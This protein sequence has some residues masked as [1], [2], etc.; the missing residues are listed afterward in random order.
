[1]SWIPRPERR[2]TRD[3]IAAGA[4]VCATA[5]FVGGT[6]VTSQQAKVDRS[7]AAAPEPHKSTATNT[8]DST[9]QH[10]AALPDALS[11]AWQAPQPSGQDPLP[12]NYGIMR[13]D[14]TRATMLDTA[15]GNER[16]HYDQQRRICGATQP[17][18]WKRLALVF[19]GPKGCGEAIGFDPATGHYGRTRD[20]LA[21]SEVMVFNGENRAG[22]ISPER[23]ELWREDLVRTVEVGH[24]E[25]PAQPNSQV[26]LEC[27]FTSALVSEELLATVQHCDDPSKKLVRL[28]RPAPEESDKPE[29]IHE[30]TVPAGSELIAISATEAAIY[31][32]ATA[33]SPPRI[34]TLHTDGVFKS[35][36]VPEAPDFP[37]RA[38]VGVDKHL[39]Q[40]QTYRKDDVQTWFDG[41]RLYLFDAATLEK[42]SVV[43][44]A[45]G[46][47][48]MW[49]K[50]LLVP[51]RQGIV[52]VDPST[53]QQLR[54]V[55]V[56]RG[57]YEGPVTVYVAGGSLV[58]RRG[59]TLVGLR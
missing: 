16:W 10:F 30:F 20:A 7:V 27:R 22:T 58:E 26:R 46:T 34:Q 38:M 32:P 17:E 8:P 12:T 33:D 18:G 39:A 57:G 53:G 19:S 54:T 4:L 48:A 31:A 23:V 59:D 49:G 43:E 3:R 41:A 13:I 25:A 2:T 55:R 6:A 56:D 9:T 1:M 51:T 52:E 14:G 50:T 45:V 24:Q 37:Q 35:V 28:L 21:A 15:S 5:L 42:H 47:G 36:N 40:P 44:G 11:T 29:M